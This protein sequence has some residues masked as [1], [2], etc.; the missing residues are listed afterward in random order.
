MNA[1]QILN[2]LMFRFWIVWFRNGRAKLWSWPFQNPKFQYQNK[3]A[4]IVSKCKLRWIT[5]PGT[6]FKNKL[7]F[8]AKKVI[9]WVSKC[10]SMCE[11]LGIRANSSQARNSDLCEQD[12]G[13]S[14]SSLGISL[15]NR[16]LKIASRTNLDSG[17]WFAKVCP[18]GGHF[19]WT[20]QKPNAIPNPNAFNHLNT[21]HTVFEPPLW[22]KCPEIRWELF[23]YV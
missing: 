10:V 23:L 11:N 4:V 8:R 14:L 18:N 7:A 5:W 6:L 15:G 17:P 13:S 20:I 1:I 19:V 16:G 9:I 21:E 22:S 12:L 3:M 2:V